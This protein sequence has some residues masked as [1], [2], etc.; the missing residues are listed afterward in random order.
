MTI[1]LNRSI[2]LIRIFQIVQITT[3]DDVAHAVTDKI[4]FAD[5]ISQLVNHRLQ[6]LGMFTNRSSRTGIF[7]IYRGERR[8]VIQVATEAAHRRGRANQTVQHDHDPARGMPGVAQFDLPLQMSF[9]IRPFAPAMPVVP[10]VDQA[11]VARDGVFLDSPSST[12]A[13]V[14]PELFPAKRFQFQVE[15]INMHATGILPTSVLST[16]RRSVE[17]KP[18]HCDWLPTSRHRYE[19]QYSP[20]IRR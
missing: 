20:V 8:M 7:K 16:S 3:N 1:R 17:W 5:V 2:G 15:G 12:I 4:D 11:I 14:R 10:V 9:A 6:C 19:R 18:R 13:N